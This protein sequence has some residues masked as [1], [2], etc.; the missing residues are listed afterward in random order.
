M[1]QRLAKFERRTLR[2]I[3]GSGAV[4]AVVQQADITEQ[5]VIPA[6]TALQELS[7]N[8]AQR[9]DAID[10]DKKAFRA[11]SVWGRLSWVIFGE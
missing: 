6:L 2:K 4:Q 1:N 8:F 7:K 9:L 3:V 5:T 11:K 10:A